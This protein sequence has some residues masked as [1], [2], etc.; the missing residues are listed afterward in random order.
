MSTWY[1]ASCRRRIGHPPRATDHEPSSRY[2]LPAMPGRSFSAQSPCAD[3]LVT[4]WA[5]PSLRCCVANTACRRLVRRQNPPGYKANLGRATYAGRTRYACRRNSP[6]QST[7]HTNTPTPNP[8]HSCVSVPSLGS[9]CLA[10][11][12]GVNSV[13]SRRLC[14]LRIHLASQHPA[15][16]LEKGNAHAGK[17]RT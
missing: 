7:E 3:I 6:A 11:P 16:P 12:H 13:T 10:I 5:H 9:H 2:P 4:R 1:S 15:T 14:R 8:T 17:A